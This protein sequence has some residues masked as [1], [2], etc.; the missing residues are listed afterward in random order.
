MEEER[1]KEAEKIA[2]SIKRALDKIPDNY[3]VI[4]SDNTVQVYDNEYLRNYANETGDIDSP[5][6]LACEPVKTN[7]I[8]FENQI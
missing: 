7:V 6:W 5:D 1:I 8:G 4:I 3:S 2:R